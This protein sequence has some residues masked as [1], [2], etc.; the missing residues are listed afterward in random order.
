MDDYPE[1]HP[2]IRENPEPR[3]SAVSLAEFLILKADPQADV[4]HNSRYSQTNIR[5]AYASA[6]HGLR[7]YN[8][9]PRRPIGPLNKVKDTLLRKAENP[10]LKK[11]ARTSYLRSAELIDLFLLR[12]NALGLRALPLAKAPRFEPLDVAGLELSIQ[13][14][15]MVEP[16]N[17]RIGAAILRVTKAPDP[18]DCR[19]QSTKDER[20]EHRR[21]MA[22]YLVAMLEMLLNS[23]PAFRGRVDRSLIFV[24]DVRLGEKI[25]AG[26]GHD[27][28]LRDIEAGCRQVVSLW[29][30]VKPR[31]SI[32]KKDD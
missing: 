32:L 18:D 30:D 16:P 4:L 11:R 23:Q 2:S 17:G 6:R 27:G 1:L 31:P 24:S 13:P 26:P 22:R 21:E 10:D 8:L 12:E 5:A 3:M 28:L 19:R 7:L 29:S 20:G 25:G 14:D 9:D 15:F